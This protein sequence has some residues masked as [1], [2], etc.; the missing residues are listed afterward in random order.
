MAAA[1]GTGA[2]ID[3]ARARMRAGEFVFVDAGCGIGGSLAYCEKLFGRGR[4]IG[5]DASAAK[6]AEATAAGHAAY[7]ADLATIDLPERSVLFVSL[8][9]FVEHLPGADATRAILANLGRV[10]RDFLFIRHPNFED[11]ER[12]ASHGLK[13]DWTDWHG[14]TN[15]LRLA[16]LDALIRGLGWPAA[17]V[18]AQKPI[19]DSGHPS[20]VPL[21]APRD[22]VGYDAERHGPKALV[23]FDRP[24]YTQFDLF[25][26]VNPAL[27]DAEWTRI[28]R[29]VARKQ[30]ETTRLLRADGLD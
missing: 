25:V 19:L 29:R 13:L 7:Q 2:T 6:I 5:F 12:L 28:T 27:T 3:E 23:A 9:D 30:G 18:F 16:E 1:A 26:R 24:V 22:T 8:L 14:H 15:M 21:S 10:A 17:T 20:V 4:G 11:I